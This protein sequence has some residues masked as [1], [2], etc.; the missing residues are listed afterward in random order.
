M[1]WKKGGEGVSAMRHRHPLFGEPNP[2][3]VEGAGAE[4]GQVQGG[5]Q[6]GQREGKGWDGIGDG[7]ELGGGG[8]ERQHPLPLTPS[9]P[10]PPSS[11][12]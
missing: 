9:L 10:S 6:R 8:G 11:H 5:G 2:N 3:P 12:L 1:K 4:Q 7:M